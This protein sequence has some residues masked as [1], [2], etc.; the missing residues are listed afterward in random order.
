[1]ETPTGNMVI[2]IG[3]GTTEIAVIALSASSAT[4]RSARAAT[5]SIRRSCS[6]CARITICL[7]RAHGRADQDQHRLGG[8]CRRRARDEVKGR[9]L[10]SASKRRSRVHSV[11]FA[12]RF[13]SRFGRD[14]GRRAP[15]VGDHARRSSPA[16]FVDRGI[17]MTGAARSFAD[18]IFCSARKRVAHSRR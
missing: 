13:R 2:D 16:T 10:V 5:S 18:W 17:V 12:K 15:R 6:S 8:A 9:D 3:G 4:R 1:V 7:R 14:R 11:R